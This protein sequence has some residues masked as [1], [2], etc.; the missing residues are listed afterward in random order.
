ML[1]HMHLLAYMNLYLLIFLGIK[2]MFMFPFVEKFFTGLFFA[3]VDDDGDDVKCV[4]AVEL[5]AFDASVE[6]G[7]CIGN[8]QHHH[9]Q[10]C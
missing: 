10:D 3:V 2:L 7:T 5:P 6:M 1:Y 9:T 8:G 4:L